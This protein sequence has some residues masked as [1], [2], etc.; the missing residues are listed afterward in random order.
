MKQNDSLIFDREWEEK[1]AAIISGLE[2]TS[3]I[4]SE[5]LNTKCGLVWQI[6]LPGRAHHK[7]AL[8]LTF[9]LFY[10]GLHR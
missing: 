6:R 9:M 10:T 1:V 8:A 4:I 3:K 2:Q 5:L 7:V